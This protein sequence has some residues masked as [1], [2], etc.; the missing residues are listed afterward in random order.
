[1]LS[2]VLL[3]CFVVI[4]R[5]LHRRSI[6]SVMGNALS[7]KICYLATIFWYSTNPFRFLLSNFFPFFRCCFYF[8]SRQL[9]ILWCRFDRTNKNKWKQ[10]KRV[11]FV[12]FKWNQFFCT[13]NPMPEMYFVRVANWK[14]SLKFNEFQIQID[15]SL[16]DFNSTAYN[17]WSAIDESLKRHAVQTDFLASFQQ[18]KSPFF[19][20]IC[21]R[22]VRLVRNKRQTPNANNFT[23]S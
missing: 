2:I 15:L 19:S 20:R 16:D 10:W 21:R 6:D 17:L 9:E 1:M 11:R 4:S 3:L 22:S 23:D 18:N 8:V 5:L 13:H 12:S 14:I 7:N